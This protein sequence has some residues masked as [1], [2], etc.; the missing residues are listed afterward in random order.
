M[1]AEP[2]ITEFLLARIAEDEAAATEAAEDEIGG[3]ED[4]DQSV[5]DWPQGAPTWVAAFGSFADQNVAR[6]ELSPR[7]ALAECEAK[8]RIVDEYEDALAG[9]QLAPFEG[10]HLET[11][12]E[13]LGYV[14]EL[15]AKLYSDH[16][17]YRED[18][19]AEP[20]LTYQTD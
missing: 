12:R 8:R 19:A 11:A 18:W 3:P 16:P 13:L 9:W 2:T 4:P 7:R 1:A 10:A 5:V 14:V 20:A 17:D 6:V 15:L